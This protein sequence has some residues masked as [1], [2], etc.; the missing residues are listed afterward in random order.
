MRTPNN[1]FLSGIHFEQ[2][3][4]LKRFDNKQHRFYLLNWHRRA[5][6]TTLVLNI[7]IK[8][9]LANDNSRYGYIAP[10]YRSAK[11]IVWRDP[12]ML[13]SYLPQER[14]KK[15]N[16][17]EMFIE[18]DN[19]SIFTLHGSD[20]P[21]SLRGIDFSGVCLD[22]FALMKIMLW[23]E[24]VRPI[25]A[26]SK[27]RWAIF[28]FTP[29]GQNH[30]FDYW[31]NSEIWGDEWHR[32]RLTASKSGIIPKDE[33]VKMRNEMPA[34]LY[35]Q[36][37]ECSFVAEEQNVLI[38][39]KMI[40]DLEG[41][42]ITKPKQKKIISCDPSIGGDECVIYIMMDGNVIDELILHER[43]TMKIAGQ[44]LILSEKH[45]IYDV[46]I[47]SIGVGAG[48]AD[49]L[50]EMQLRVNKFNSAEN[51]ND[52]RFANKRSQAYWY[53]M[54]QMR[55]KNI[56]QPQC[57]KLT[58]QLVNVPFKVINSNGKIILLP[59]DQIKKVIGESPDRADAFVQGVYGLQY[60]EDWVPSKKHDAYSYDRD[61]GYEFNP[62]TC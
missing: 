17:T 21:D 52:N 2:A 35:D 55:D 24:I 41:L 19:G 12:N 51:P 8:E 42:K 15:I 54:E 44:I 11:D 29:K 31:T 59:K 1:K 26:Q 32:S 39:T 57:S 25:I 40:A 14:V 61:E 56:E 45:K 18:F 20:N 7:L 5:R 47:D 49:R 43:D 62:A 4:I 6:K 30:A 9:A 27:N 37:M 48:I 16:E 60:V 53:T 28:T 13:K 10:T 22:E 23:E 46:I 3:D 38:T 36:E 33:L 50:Q 58:K 34:V